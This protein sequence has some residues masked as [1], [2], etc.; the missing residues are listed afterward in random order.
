MNE[1][2]ATKIIDIQVLA[3]VLALA[4]RDLEDQDGYIKDV[5]RDISIRADNALTQIAKD[6]GIPDALRNKLYAECAEHTASIREAALGVARG[7]R[8]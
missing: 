3:T 2:M 4:T 7:L 5:L 6:S 8:S 1:G